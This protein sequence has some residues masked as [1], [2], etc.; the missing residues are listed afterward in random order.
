MDGATE[1]GG[2]EGSF[3]KAARPVKTRASRVRIAMVSLAVVLGVGVYVFIDQRGHIPPLPRVVLPAAAQDEALAQLISRTKG[4]TPDAHDLRL[5]DA[6]KS[7]CRVESNSAARG[8]A[9]G[10]LAEHISAFSKLATD[11][12]EQN[13]ARYL[14]LGDHLAVAF[15][16]SLAS[17]LAEIRSRG[18]GDTADVKGLD[19]MDQVLALGGGF[20]NRAINRGVITSDGRL[21]APRI[22][23]QVVFRVRWRHFAELQLDLG[24]TSVDRQAYLDFIIAYANP[25]AMSRRLKAVWALKQLNPTYDAVLARAVVMHQAGEN[26]RARET[27]QTAVKDGY[28]RDVSSFVRALEP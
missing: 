3:V 8:D 1:K 4:F 23:P 6:L 15:H 28:A 22:G 21:D 26:E 19:G 10:E 17:V 20:L 12:A 9:T 2:S 16:T 14:L 7:L 13:R 25:D 5:V 18:G 24:L 11:R 27:L